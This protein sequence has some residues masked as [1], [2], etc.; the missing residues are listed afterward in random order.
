[1]NLNDIYATEW[2][3]S[4][5][6][7]K[8]GTVSTEFSVDGKSCV[9]EHEN[10]TVEAAH[11]YVRELKQ[12]G[13][14][15]GEDYLLGENFYALRY[16][17]KATVYVSYSAKAGT[18]RLYAEGKGLNQYPEKESDD[19][20]P[21]FSLALWQLPVDCKG[22]KQNGGMSYVF[23]NN[24]GIFI[25]I[26]G[27]Y[28]TSVEAENLYRFLKEHTPGD[29]APVIEAWYFS[30][31]HGDH[32]GAMY[33]FSKKYSHEIKVKSFYYHFDYLGGANTNREMFL[34]E[35]GRN[36]WRDAVH[37]GRLHTGMEFHV[38]GI[39]FQVLY[40]L[41]DIY[42]TTAADGIEFNNTSTVLLATVKGQKVLFLGDVMNIASDCMMKY[43][44]ADVLKS[45]IVQFSHHGYEGG[46]KELYD[47]IA[48]STVLWPLNVDGYQPTGYKDIP[49]NVFKIWHVKTKGH[50]AMPN[51]Y[52]CYEAPYV[53]KII[54]HA[55]PVKLE[56][57][58][59]PEGE[60]L[61]DL[62]AVFAEKTME[63]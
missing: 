34:Q 16:G 59:S 50:Y 13:F 15:A 48:A 23:S 45:D 33:A 4:I 6:A 46:S 52:I 27:G 56:F 3:A 5:P 35:T 53:K 41:E 57:P 54:P 38:R 21:S 17:E 7:L 43:L 61:P 18:V 44:S 55:Y 32:F 63:V 26:D 10:Y 51:Y 60:K 12:N 9:I 29:K 40:T 11:D 2:F 1:M 37:Y 49:Q 36:L 39:S 25:I 22:S 19:A 42:P 58:Y 20:A 31:L 24:D 62:D 30:H 47:S 8:A 28:N 14:E